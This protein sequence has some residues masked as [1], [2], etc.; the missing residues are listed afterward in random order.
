MIAFAGLL[1][2]C[3]NIQLKI[4]KKYDNLVQLLYLGYKH[5][6]Q[7]FSIAGIENK[8]RKIR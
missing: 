6:K 2:I 1:G 3:E 7:G 5:E 8:N 4:R